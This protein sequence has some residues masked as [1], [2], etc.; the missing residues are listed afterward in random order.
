MG[1]VIRKLDAGLHLKTAG[2]TW[3]EEVIGLASAGGSG[4][5]IAKAIYRDAFDRVDELAKPYETVIEIDRQKLPPPGTVDAWSGSQFVS[6][7]RHDRRDP[8]YNIHFRQLLHIGFRVA[9]EMGKEYLDALR[10]NREA[11][12]RNVSENLWDRHIK[13]LF[14]A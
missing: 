6:A 4:L 7:L 12:A 3:L 14:L 8:A 1:K 11:V 9:A 13:P 10:Q 5:A 2:T